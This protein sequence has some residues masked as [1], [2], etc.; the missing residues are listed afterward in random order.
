MLEKCAYPAC[1]A[2]FHRL[3]E[4]RLFIREVE[5][6]P[7]DG[8]VRSRQLCCCWLCDSCRGTVTVFTERGNE[9]KVAPLPVSRSAAQAAW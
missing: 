1:S 8:R 2:T 4:G 6:G 7:R 5:A 9:I 3:G